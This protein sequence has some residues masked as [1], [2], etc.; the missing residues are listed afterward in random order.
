VAPRRSRTI[1]TNPLD[2]VIPPTSAPDGLSSSNNAAPHPRFLRATIRLPAHI[3]ERARNAVY[4]TP[5]LTLEQ[6][7]ERA[8]SLA[9]E[10]TEREHGAPFAPRRHDLQQGRRI[11]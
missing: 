11:Q 4:W 5:G 3:L 9:L 7:A 2:A 1:G 10:E 6:L 8:F